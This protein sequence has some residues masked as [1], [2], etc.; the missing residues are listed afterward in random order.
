MSGGYWE[1]RDDSLRSDIFG[2]DDEKRPVPDVFEDVVISN[3][4]HDMFDLMHEF[5][6]YKSGDTN[7]NTYKKAVADFKKKWFKDTKLTFGK[8]IDEQVKALEE[9]LKT[10]LD[11]TFTLP[12]DED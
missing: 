8:L 11:D 4:I 3:I 6:W 5:D 12:K 10:A 9:R 7:E 2:W 1:Y